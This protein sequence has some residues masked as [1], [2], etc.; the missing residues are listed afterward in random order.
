VVEVLQGGAAHCCF[1]VLYSATVR[2]AGAQEDANKCEQ[3]TG[4][5]DECIAGEPASPGMPYGVT[6][7]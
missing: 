4:G 7:N 1:Q 3:I 5:W 2:K 6:R